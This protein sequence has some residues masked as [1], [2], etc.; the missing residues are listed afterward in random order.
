M[1]S[2][3][4][5]ELV[6]QAIWQ[7]LLLA[8]PVLVTGLVV[9]ILIGI[10]Q[11]FTQIQDHTLGFVPKL[12]AILIVICVCLPW[13]FEKMADYSSQAFKDIPQNISTDGP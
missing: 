13:L 5:A 6:Q 3:Q 1:E 7:L 4:A 11:S 9:G 12:I 10:I 2:Y 8:S